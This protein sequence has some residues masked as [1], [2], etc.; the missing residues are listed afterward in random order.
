MKENLKVSKFRNLDPITPL[1]DSLQWTSYGNQTGQEGWCYYKDNSAYNSIYGKLYNWYAVTDPRGLCPSGWHVPTDGEWYTMENF[2]DPTVND[3]DA[4]YGRG[5]VIGGKLKAV[6][7]PWTLPNSEATNSSGFTALPGGV[8]C[9]GIFFRL[10]DDGFWWTSTV[11]G[12]FQAWIRNLN[13]LSV[14]SNKDGNYG[15]MH[16]GFSVRC[17]KD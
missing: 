14:E 10:R 3:P 13:Y 12:A 15:F 16:D 8:R 7:S 17:I 11:V 9:E 6:S 5:T 1:L 2:L 4:L